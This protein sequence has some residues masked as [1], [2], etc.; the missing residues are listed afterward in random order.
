VAFCFALIQ[1]PAELSVT[2]FGDDNRA[3]LPARDFYAR[4]GFHAAEMTSNGPEGGTRQV[5]RRQFVD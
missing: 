4:M 3:G 5:F 2:T 1:P